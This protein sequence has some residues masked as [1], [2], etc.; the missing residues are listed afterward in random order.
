M[1]SKTIEKPKRGWAVTP[2]L[3][4]YGKVCAGF[5]WDAA[6]RELDGLPLK[7]RRPGW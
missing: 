7:T 2:N 6:R 4:D 5:S 1:I 3:L